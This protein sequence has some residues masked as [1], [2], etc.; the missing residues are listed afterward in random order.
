MSSANVNT[1]HFTASNGGYPQ[2]TVGQST[3]TD[4]A[5]A[6]KAFYDAEPNSLDAMV[7]IYHAPGY[8]YQAAGASRGEKFIQKLDNQLDA[9]FVNFKEIYRQVVDNKGV[10]PAALEAQKSSP[11]D[12]G[13]P[14]F[15]NF[16]VGGETYH[17]AKSA[18]RA[19]ID[20]EPTLSSAG[21]MV[22]R[23]PGYSFEVAG[24]DAKGN[25]YLNKLA[26]Q[27]NAMMKDF[28]SAY[29]EMAVN[30]Q[31]PA[32]IGRAPEEPVVDT[33]EPTINSAP[34]AVT[35]SAEETT[36]V[37]IGQD[38]YPNFT[39]G[40]KIYHDARTAAQAF[41]DAEPSLGHAGV[42]VNRAPG[43]SFEVAGADAKGNK[44]LNKLAFQDNAMMQ[45]FKAAYDE[46]VVLQSPAVQF[47]NK[48]AQIIEKADNNPEPLPAYEPDVTPVNLAHQ[49]YPHFV[50]G[51]KVYNDAQ[52]A[53][54]AFAEMDNGQAFSSVMINSAPG[55]GFEA[56]GVNARGAKYV[57]K[58][59]HQEHP[60]LV[61]FKEAYAGYEALQEIEIARKTGYPH[62]DIGG[63][64]YFDP[65]EAALAFSKMEGIPHQTRVRII[66]SESDFFGIE[67]AGVAGDGTKF[68]NNLDFQSNPQLKGFKKAFKEVQAEAKNEA[69]A[70]NPLMDMLSKAS[71]G[72][73]VNSDTTAF[74]K[75]SNAVKNERKAG[76]SIG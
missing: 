72:L 50:I 29:E 64:K 74:S 15:P 2:Y 33:V 58:L 57:N 46:M 30:A 26:F 1:P 67:A 36:E 23:A 20:A 73:K 39:V 16:T 13:Q 11:V 40:G 9:F 8:G 19:F 10:V 34:E 70:T 52:E 59:D 25:K 7:M 49:G 62:Y 24:A 4:A 22:N 75:F 12:I 56:A 51:Q 69:V 31:A 60:L 5:A 61:E 32:P 14:Q 27:D 21:V 45:D 37:K 42:L 38:G 17:D 48:A 76:L 63:E 44:Y 55:Y 3:Y 68:V 28:K 66:T 18:A 43:Y 47:P 35:P 41:I 65:K 71:G 53:A 6:A 54:K